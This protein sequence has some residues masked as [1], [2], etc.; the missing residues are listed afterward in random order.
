VRTIQK[1]VTGSSASKV[2]IIATGGGNV[3]VSD[4][5]V[6]EYASQKA[7]LERTNWRGIEKLLY[8]VA[9]FTEGSRI[10]F[11]SDIFHSLAIA[12]DPKYKKFTSLF[13]VGQRSVD[14]QDI[15]YYQVISQEVKFL[16]I[17]RQRGIDKIKKLYAAR[18]LQGV[19]REELLMKYRA[20]MLEE[21]KR[22]E[23]WRM[24]TKIDFA[25]ERFSALEFVYDPQTLSISVSEVDEYSLDPA[26]Y[27]DHLSTTSELLKYAASSANLSVGYLGDIGWAMNDFRLMKIM[28]R[29][30]DHNAIDVG[31]IRVDSDDYERW[32][33]SNPEFEAEVLR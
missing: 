33:Y 3:T 31:A 9:A 12:F 4:I 17:L 7:E 28:I 18:E 32:D 30:L 1:K 23:N 21:N 14:G 22:F 2:H 15:G 26:S 20:D 19:E 8:T 24:Q 10:R 27:P 5:T 13:N 16:N 29:M 6:Y 11:C 25:K